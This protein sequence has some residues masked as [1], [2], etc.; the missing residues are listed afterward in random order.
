[1]DREAVEVE[2]EVGEGPGDVA[3]DAGERG[4]GAAQAQDAG[5]LEEG[6]GGGLV[7]VADAGEVDEDEAGVRV[8]AELGEGVDDLAAALGVDGADEGEDE[9]VLVDRDQG[10]GALAEG[11]ALG[12][13]DGVAELGAGAFAGDAGADV[14]EEGDGGDDLVVLVADGGGGDAE[15]AA[16]AVGI[17]EVA[18]AGDELAGAG[19]HSREALVG[20]DALVAVRVVERERVVVGV[21]VGAQEVLGGVVEAAGGGAEVVDLD[22]DGEVVEDDL[23]GAG[24]ALLVGEGLLAAAGEEAV[25]EDG[26]EVRG[27]RLVEAHLVGGEDARADPAELDEAEPAAL[28]AQGDEDGG[29]Q[30]AAAAAL[31]DAGVRVVAHVAEEHGRVR[32]VEPQGGGG[33]VGDDDGAV[34]GGGEAGVA[35]VDGDGGD[36]LRVAALVGLD[37]EELALD[38]GDGDLGE[39]GGEDG[40]GVAGGGDPLA[41]A[42]EGGEAGHRVGVGGEGVAFGE[43]GGEVVG[44][45]GVE[46][47]LVGIGAVGG[48]PVEGEL[49]EPL[50]ARAG[51]GPDEVAEREDAAGG[52]VE[53]EGVGEDRLGGALGGLGR[54]ICGAPA[55]HGVEVGGD[56][57]ARAGAVEDDLGGAA[58]GEQ[59]GDRGEALEVVAGAD[60][61][62]L[63]VAETTQEVVEVGGLGAHRRDAN[64]SR[65]RG[66]V[67]LRAGRGEDV[68]RDRSAA[69]EAVGAGAA[70]LS[71]RT[72]QRRTRRRAR[73]MPACREPSTMMPA[74]SM[75]AAAR[76]AAASGPRPVR[77]GRTPR[78][79]R[80]RAAPMRR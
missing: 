42:E 38:V 49:A 75:P 15:A 23:E 35:A 13:D 40:V 33:G 65:G 28:P 76:L 26:G 69:E 34:E 43:G 3:A 50:L 36:G 19:G 73:A 32:V 10:G 18:L 24:L 58:R 61:G 37:G 54:G 12:R 5:G 53:R 16:G 45:D 55:G 39:H 68:R 80:A 52:V 51:R 59:R 57:G 56:V 72:G 21:D 41:D 71:E 63:D 6:A 2:R 25:V 60:E 62:D 4:P 1:M 67:R 29:E 77:I 8:A 70:G 44:E 20:A 48:G 7:E 78:R 22:A 27:E 79:R 30:A 11:G 14:V 17:E 66:R 47:A 9:G 74:R 46:E 64:R 31:A